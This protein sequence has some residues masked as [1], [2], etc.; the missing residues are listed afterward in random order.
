MITK[1]IVHL[2]I[3]VL[4]IIVGIS[5]IYHSFVIVKPGTR[6]VLI[7]MGKVGDT[8]L[9]EG[10]H[11]IIPY[12][13]KVIPMN[14]QTTKVELNCSAASKDLQVI[15]ATVALN[16]HIDP[17]RANVV[18]Q[19][20]KGDI[21]KT[22]IDPKIQESVKAATARYIAPDLVNYREM[23]KSE[24]KDSLSKRLLTADVILDDFNIVNFAYNPEFQAAIEAKQTA[25]QEALAAENQVRTS[26]AQAA[27]LVAEAKGIAESNRLKQLSITK[28]LL[29][30]ENYQ[31]QRSL[32]AA[33]EKTGGKV[34]TTVMVGGTAKNSSLPNVI[35]NL[36]Q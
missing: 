30:W 8:A 4:L 17:K 16:Y 11:A 32:I 27:K 1:R 35:L 3:R 33:W 20:I 36:G 21:E 13:Q 34:P 2:V 22:I 28:E 23:V 31:V 15:S 18:Y 26:T 6:G 10:L 5:I 7:T 14:V 12:V 19:T 9:T 24:I 25:T 29:E